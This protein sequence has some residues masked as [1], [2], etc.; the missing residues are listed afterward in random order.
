MLRLTVKNRGRP[1]ATAEPPHDRVEQILD[2]TDIVTHDDG[3]RYAMISPALLNEL[4]AIV[5][6]LQLGG[7]VPPARNEVT[8]SQP[9]GE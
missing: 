8:Y 3:F 1:L 5:R 9:K 7:D 2:E 4:A 6:G